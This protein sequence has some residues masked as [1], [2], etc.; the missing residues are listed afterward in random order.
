MSPT[1]ILS[2]QLDALTERWWVPVVRGIA[3]ILFGVLALVAPSIGL[4]ALV[5]MWGVY[6]IADG[7]FN[8][9]LATWAGRAGARFGWYLFEGIVSIAAGVLT[10]LYPGITAV[11]LLFVIA[12][13]AIVT[14][15]FEIAAAVQL[16]RAVSGEWMLGLAGVLSIVFGVLL[17]AHPGAGALAV[18]W[19][20]G[21]YAIV[22][23]VLL[24]GLGVRL[25][26]LHGAGKGGFPTSGTPHAA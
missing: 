16:R 3:A 20:I 10:F 26:R 2:E 21:A 15:I 24:I 19:L 9:F 5:V 11:A 13:W 8:L 14:G 4:F 23:G 22:F 6:A 17:F 1:D 18:V 12:G 7:I 25:H